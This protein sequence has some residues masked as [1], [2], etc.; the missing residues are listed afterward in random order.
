VSEVF[1]D[2]ASGEL[3]DDLRAAMLEVAEDRKRRGTV[4]ARFLGLAVR[5]IRER[6]FGSLRIVTGAHGKTGTTFQV[7]RRG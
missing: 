1:D 6:W 2:Q 7:E 4:S 5:S 3:V